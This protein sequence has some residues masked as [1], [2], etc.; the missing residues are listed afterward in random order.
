M[1][2]VRWGVLSTALIGTQRVLPGMRKSKTLEIAAIASR[3][4]AKARAAADELGIPTAYGSYEELLADPAIEA[5]YNPLPNHLHVSM[6]LAALKARIVTLP[7]GHSLMQEL[8]DGVL[9]ALQ[10]ALTRPL[11][12]T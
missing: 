3:E 2:L 10:A 8:P 7:G 12:S 1:S 5:V 11:E 6:T 4:L 9:N